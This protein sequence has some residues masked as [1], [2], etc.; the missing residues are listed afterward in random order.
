MAAGR[1][2]STP[3]RAAPRA[4]RPSII[5]ARVSR[6]CGIIGVLRAVLNRIPAC[7]PQV[8]H[9]NV[10]RIHDLGDLNDMKY[11]TM[12]FIE[13]EDLSGITGSGR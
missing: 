13:G 1:Y 6:I 9:R 11:M 8:T 2:G 5:S 7:P 3:A 12:P 10:V 4:C